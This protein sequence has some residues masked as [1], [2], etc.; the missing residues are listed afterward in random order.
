MQSKFYYY[1]FYYY[2]FYYYILLCIIYYYSAQHQ[3]TTRAVQKLLDRILYQKILQGKRG[4]HTRAN[5]HK[6]TL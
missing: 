3:Q 2:K 6:P 5:G 1:E 4:F